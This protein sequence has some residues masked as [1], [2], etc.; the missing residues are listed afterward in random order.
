MG[1]WQTNPLDRAEPE[2]SAASRPSQGVKAVENEVT[3]QMAPLLKRRPSTEVKATEAGL[4][5]PVLIVLRDVTL[6]CVLRGSS[7]WN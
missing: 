3:R 4:G 2:S 5:L 7:F 1:I 6:S